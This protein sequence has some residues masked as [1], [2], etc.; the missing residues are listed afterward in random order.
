[1]G[2]GMIKK[3]GSERTGTTT[4]VDPDEPLR[5]ILGAESAKMADGE[6]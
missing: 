5:R 3:E 2:A 1:M 4:T 6:A